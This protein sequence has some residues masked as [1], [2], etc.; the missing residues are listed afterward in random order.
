M[1]LEGF[2][3]KLPYITSAHIS[4]PKVGHMAKPDISG[5]RSMEDGWRTT[6]S[7]V[8]IR[9]D[10]ESLGTCKKICVCVCFHYKFSK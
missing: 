6:A 1:A 8:A 7:Y 9:K 3:L 10:Q 5:I 2:C 4:L